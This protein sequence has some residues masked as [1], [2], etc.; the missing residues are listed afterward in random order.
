MMMAANI[1]WGR[2]VFLMSRAIKIYK[3]AKTSSAFTLF[4]ENFPL[5]TPELEEQFVSQVVK[6]WSENKYRR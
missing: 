3:P 2:K 1:G 4:N 6:A 5:I